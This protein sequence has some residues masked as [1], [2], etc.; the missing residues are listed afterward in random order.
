MASNRSRIAAFAEDCLDSYQEYSILD[1]ICTVI[2]YDDSQHQGL[3]Y[4]GVGKRITLPKTVFADQDRDTIGIESDIGKAAFAGERNFLLETIRQNAIA[5]AI[6]EYSMASFDQDDIVDIVDEHRFQH[7]FVPQQHGSDADGVERLCRT[8]HS[9]VDTGNLYLDTG[10]TSVRVHIVPAGSAMPDNRA[11]LLNHNKITTVQ[12]RK[13]SADNPDGM[14]LL[15][16]YRDIGAGERLM[17]YVGDDPEG[18]AGYDFFYRVV[19]SEPAIEQHGAAS[20]RVPV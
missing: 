18:E 13:R 20:V 4:T 7:L 12:Q 3:T 2:E 17:L 15:D 19:L 8:M 11:Y 5:G 6:D 9:Y 1:D 10:D 16:E 14:E